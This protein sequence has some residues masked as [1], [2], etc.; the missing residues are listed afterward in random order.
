MAGTF[1][2][3]Q[4]NPTLWQFGVPARA[5]DHEH[6]VFASYEVMQ[7]DFEF[8]QLK[9]GLVSASNVDCG[10][11]LRSFGQLLIG[12][13]GYQPLFDANGNSTGG[14]LTV[15]TSIPLAGIDLSEPSWLLLYINVLGQG[16]DGIGQQLAQTGGS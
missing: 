10:Q 4:L 12:A 14:M 11:L 3:K 7:P 9:T 8:L 13:I 16:A 5:G 6:D 2:A 1:G 15:S